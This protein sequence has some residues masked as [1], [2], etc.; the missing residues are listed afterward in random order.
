MVA[1]GPGLAEKSR[2]VLKEPSTMKRL[3]LFALAVLFV[4]SACTS[5]TPSSASGPKPTFSALL[6]T[7]NENPPISNAESTGSG[8]ATITFDLTRDA[9]GNV[10]AASATFVLNV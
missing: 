3:A 10:T 2:I 4:A 9:A 6:R 8:N 7:S 1:A 5:D